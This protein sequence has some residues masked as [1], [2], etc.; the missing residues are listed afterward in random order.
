MLPRLIP[1]TVAWRLTL[2][3]AVGSIIFLRSATDPPC[4]ARRTKKIVLQRQLSDLR[5]QGLHVDHRFRL[6][7]RSMAEDPGRT[8]EQLVAPLLDLVRMDVEILRQ[9]DQRLLALDRGH[10]HF[11]L[12][13]RAVV[14]ARSSC[15]GLLLARSIMLPLR[16]KSTYAG[17]SDF[18]NH[19]CLSRVNRMTTQTIIR[20]LKIKSLGAGERSTPVP[21]SPNW[22]TP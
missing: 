9:F 21:S 15:H 1:S 3:L 18:W 13:F 19:L 11:R 6:G 5:M 7:R 20:T 14:P 2:S 12:E 16:G 17:C 8:L 22:L 4:R 10:R